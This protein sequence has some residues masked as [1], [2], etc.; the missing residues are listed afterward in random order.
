MIY[1]FSKTDVSYEIINN[2]IVLLNFKTGSY[3]NI[4][5]VGSDI[6]LYLNSSGNIE[7]LFLTISNYFKLDI[8]AIKNDILSFIEKLIKDG[9]II[10]LDN[11]PSNDNFVISFNKYEKPNFEKFDDLTD[12]LILDNFDGQDERWK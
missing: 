2:E 3:Y 7:A 9:N 5:R 10:S 4:N 8:N 12:Q 1:T 6:C 11:C